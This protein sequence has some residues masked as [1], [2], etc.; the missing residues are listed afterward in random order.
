ML[1][2]LWN[3]WM[4]IAD[5]FLLA[6]QSDVL[7]ITYIVIGFLFLYTIFHPIVRFIMTLEWTALMT[8]L[9]VIISMF[10]FL[11]SVPQAPNVKFVIY[12]MLIF[13]IIISSKRGIS[14][15]KQLRKN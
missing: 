15:I 4:F 12:A 11:D 6:I 1:R 9:L 5:Y 2:E 3:D 13:S 14:L 8:Y 10:L 7:L